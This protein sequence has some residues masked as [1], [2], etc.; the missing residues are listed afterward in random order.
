MVTLMLEHGHVSFM[1]FYQGRVRKGNYFSDLE[2]F[3]L[4]E[5]VLSALIYLQGIGMLGM[6]HHEMLFLTLNR[7]Y[8][9]LHPLLF[10]LFHQSQECPE[11]PISQ[12]VFDFGYL[13]LNIALLEP[14]LKPVNS[15]NLEQ[16]Y[17]ET[18]VQILT[19]TISSKIIHMLQICLQSDSTSRPSL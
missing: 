17:L 9:S 6:F 16:S 12:S 4:A 2:L 10:P 11:T 7:N 15:Y 8:K 19:A 14:A 18:K 13:L 5:N 3:R 1:E